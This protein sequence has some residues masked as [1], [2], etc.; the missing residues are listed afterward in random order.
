MA[1]SSTLSFDG[2]QG[3]ANILQLKVITRRNYAQPPLAVAPD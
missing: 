2:N 1:L 3:N